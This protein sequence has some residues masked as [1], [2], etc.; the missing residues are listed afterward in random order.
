MH[1]CWAQ[2][3]N[4]RGYT[5]CIQRVYK[6]YTEG[7]QGVYRGYAGGGGGGGGCSHNLEISATYLSVFISAVGS[8]ESLYT[9]LS[10]PAEQDITIYCSAGGSAKPC[11]SCSLVSTGINHGDA[12]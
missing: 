11:A 9:S 3:E 8:N 4:N 2:R 1:F 12:G 10:E 6:G 5:E 7:I